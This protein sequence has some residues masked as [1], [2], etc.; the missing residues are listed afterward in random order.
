MW[1]TLFPLHGATNFTSPCAFLSGETAA[2]G[3]G[4]FA[5]TVTGR[6]STPP[7]VVIWRV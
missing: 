2:S 1:I 7:E 4:D 5:D 3:D 6:Y